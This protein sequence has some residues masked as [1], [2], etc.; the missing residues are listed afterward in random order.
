[1]FKNSQTNQSYD[2]LT[3]GYGRIDALASVQSTKPPIARLDTSGIL[4]GTV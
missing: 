1:V 2:I 3:Q 4:N